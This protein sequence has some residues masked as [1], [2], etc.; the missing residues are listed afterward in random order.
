MDASI[1]TDRQF[2]KIL[3]MVEMIMDGCKDLDQAKSKIKEL[4]D[5]DKEDKKNK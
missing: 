3:Q 1:M 4:R 2:D 5:E